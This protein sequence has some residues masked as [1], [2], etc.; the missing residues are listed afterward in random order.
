[1]ATARSFSIERVV[2]LVEI[3]NL[4]CIS[5]RKF[6]APPVLDT[7]SSCSIIVKMLR[8]MVGLGDNFSKS[9]FKS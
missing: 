3:L 1:M 4:V 2:K 9:P 7:T 8:W 5:A 6:T